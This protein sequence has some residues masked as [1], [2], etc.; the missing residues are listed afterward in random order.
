MQKKVTFLGGHIVSEDGV[1]T[2]PEKIDKVENWPVP[3]NADEL[4]S[5][6]SSVG[7]YR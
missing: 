7:Y 6:V 2:D 1:A 3:A 4:T 5:F